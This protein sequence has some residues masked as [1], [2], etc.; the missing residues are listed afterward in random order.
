[1]KV[2]HIYDYGSS[3]IRQFKIETSMLLQLLY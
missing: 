3:F 1:M 2:I